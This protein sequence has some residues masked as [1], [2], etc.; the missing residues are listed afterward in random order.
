[1]I[2]VSALA[3][4]VMLATSVSIGLPADTVPESAGAEGSTQAPEPTRPWLWLP[5]VMGAPETGFG[6]GLVGGWFEGGGV[7]ERPSSAVASALATVR[8]HRMGTLSAELYL[9]GGVHIAGTLQAQKYP[10]AFFGIG[11]RT[12]EEMEE[13][14]TARTLMAELSAQLEVRPGLSVGALARARGDRLEEMQPDGQLSAGSIPG[15]GGGS[16]VGAGVIGVLDTR[17]DLYDPASGAY[18]EVR[19]V[20]F[21]RSLGSDYD[22][23]RLTLDVRRYLRAGPRATVAARGYLA[24]TA[25]DPPF[26]ELPRIGAEGIMRGYVDGRFRDRAAAAA[27][28]EVRFPLV[29]RLGATVFG[30]VGAVAPDLLS[31][32]PANELERSVGAG[33][34]VRLNDGGVNLRI[35]VGAGREG[36]GLYLGL[37]EAF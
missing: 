22:F 15:S 28:V 27:E 3:H 31:P 17:D 20:A 8:G 25:G 10:D 14:F 5:V 4:A 13:T 26:Q 35:D 33:L 36:G 30:G 16:V 19:L 7:G 12:A 29:G 1:M 34:R 24:A 18:G 2:S 21:G 32:P 37:G 6:G 9:D 23:E 11:A